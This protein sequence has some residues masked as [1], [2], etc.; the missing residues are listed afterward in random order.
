MF[1]SNPIVRLRATLVSSTALLVACA[2]N[3]ASAQTISPCGGPTGTLWSWAWG[4]VNGSNVTLSEN[5]FGTE[6]V[7]MRDISGNGNDYFNDD[8]FNQNPPTRPAYLPSFSMNGYSTSFPVVGADNYDSGE[9]AYLQYMFPESDMNAPGGFYLAFAGYDS[10]DAG[11]RMI[12]GTT[13]D[14]FL[15]YDQLEK[16]L[17]ITIAGNSIDITGRNAWSEGPVL[18]EVWRDAANNLHAW[19]NGERRTSGS[20]SLAGTFRLN[21]I[22]GGEPA[23]G[24]A[25]D[26]HGFEYIACDGLPTPEQRAEVRE[27]LR[28]KWQLFGDTVSVRAPNPPSSLVAE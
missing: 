10:R 25:F 18:I 3:V 11:Q 21:G 12:W 13:A 19:V 15:R 5:N 23:G 27:Y 6:V 20:P 4:G 8:P 16:S 17:D 7:F 24:G 1:D 9:R 22:G 26:D 2:G 14:D 28:E